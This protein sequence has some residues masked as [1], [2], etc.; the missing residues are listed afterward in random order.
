MKLRNKVAVV[1]G[2]VIVNISSG[3]GKG[4]DYPQDLI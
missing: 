2:G 1:T 4:L 3:A